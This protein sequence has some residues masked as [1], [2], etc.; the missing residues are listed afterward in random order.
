MTTESRPD[1]GDALPVAFN[2]ANARPGQPGS[3]CS[4]WCGDDARCISTATRPAPAAADGEAVD[5]CVGT[6]GLLA[7][8]SHLTTATFHRDKV[9]PGTKLYTTPPAEAREPVE[10]TDAMQAKAMQAFWQAVAA[11]DCQPP[12]WDFARDTLTPRWVRA[13]VAAALTAA[14]PAGAVEDAGNV[15]ELTTNE[16]VIR[17]MGVA[18]VEIGEAL[19]LPQ[20]VMENPTGNEEMLEAIAELKERAALTT[21]GGGVAVDDAMVE[22]AAWLLD[23]KAWQ[24][25]PDSMSHDEAGSLY[26]WAQ[27]AAGVLR[28]LAALQA[29]HAPEKNDG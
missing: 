4:H 12:A 18:L 15:R 13:A 14:Q 17:A 9:P 23:G 29:A 1:V 22:R 25:H 20:D 10:V 6:A 21:P 16:R 7:E 3:R 19:G 8:D 26:V 5:R 28:K 11:S 24:V 27:D 2:C